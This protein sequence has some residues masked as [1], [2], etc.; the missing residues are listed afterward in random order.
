MPPSKEQPKKRIPPSER[1]DP[2]KHGL[3]DSP[4]D[5]LIDR[6]LKREPLGGKR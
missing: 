4:H 2:M 3:S 5:D 6:I 1:Y